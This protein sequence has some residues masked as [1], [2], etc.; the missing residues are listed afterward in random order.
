MLAP[1]TS[2]SNIQHESRTLKMLIYEKCNSRK[3]ALSAICKRATMPSRRYCRVAPVLIRRMLRISLWLLIINISFCIPGARAVPEGGA[4]S[5][6]GSL[7]RQSGLHRY[8]DATLIY[9]PLIPLMT[10]DSEQFELLVPHTVEFRVFLCKG[11]DSFFFFFPDWWCFCT[12]V[13]HMITKIL[14]S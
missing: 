1:K 5:Q 7:C 9:M 6:R 2:V 13:E 8:E 4:R 14:I 3:P 10:V 12:C 11:L